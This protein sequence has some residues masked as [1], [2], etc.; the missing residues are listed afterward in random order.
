MPV[1]RVEM[2]SGRSRD[3]KREIAEIITREMSRIAKCKPEAIQVVFADV[4]R[5]DWAVGGHLNDEPV[6]AR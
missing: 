3:Q 2:L 4:E 5:S 1:V 6:A